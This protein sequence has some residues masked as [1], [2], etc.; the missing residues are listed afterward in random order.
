MNYIPIASFGSRLEA[1]T[2]GNVLQ[3]NGLMSI[4]K[5]D[6]LGIGGGAGGS[7]GATLWVPEELAPRARRLLPCMF[8]EDRESGDSG[9][10]PA[11]A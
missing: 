3:E 10:A 2:F 9:C 7:F 6:D 8:P 11:G 4:V 1:E 5:S